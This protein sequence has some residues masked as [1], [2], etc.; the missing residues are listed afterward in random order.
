VQTGD[1]LG[2]IRFGSRVDL[3]LPLTAEIKVRKG[4]TVRS[5]RTVMARFAQEEKGAGHAE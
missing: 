2:L 3:F 1:R 4:D 5:A